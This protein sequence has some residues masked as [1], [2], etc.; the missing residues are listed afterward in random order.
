VA[1]RRPI[2]ARWIV[3][4]VLVAAIVFGCVEAG[5]WQ[6][7]RL[8][9]RRHLNARIRERSAE[10]VPLPDVDAATDP[11]DLTYRRVDLT[12]TYD[13]GHE[14][15]VRFRS[16]TGLP[17][18]EVLTPLRMEADVVVL[19]DRGWV[20]LEDGDRWPV[21]DMAPPPG[22]VE[23]TGLLAP[24]EGGST[25][26]EHRPDGVAVVA[27]IDP[28]KLR[29]AVGDGDLYPVYLLADEGGAGEHSSFPV[30]VDPP[31]LT[32][33]PHRSYAVQW[34]LFASVGV[35]GWIAL[36]RRRGPFAPQRSA[37]ASSASMA[38]STDADLV[39]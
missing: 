6:L 17:G 29:R 16:R 8:D 14:V 37:A 2:G 18:Y 27:A 31:A 34:F 3:G 11:D 19:V 28:A 7:R 4:T 30:A 12:G 15:L 23:V 33:G 9:Q 26:L 24:A 25:R 13:P 38:S 10:T 36:L 22:E 1:L 20:P 21:A 39:T 32:E 35:V 5:F